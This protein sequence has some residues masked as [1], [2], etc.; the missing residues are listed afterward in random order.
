MSLCLVSLCEVSNA[1]CHNAEVSLCRMPLIWVSRILSVIMLCSYRWISLCC[2]LRAKCL[3]PECHNGECHG[4]KTR[5]AGHFRFPPISISIGE[6]FR[7]KK[8]ILGERRIHN[9]SRGLSSIT[10][11][12]SPWRSY[13]V[14]WSLSVTS[15]GATFSITAYSITT[16]SITA[17]CLTSPSITTHSITTLSIITLCL[18]SLS[19]ATS[20]MQH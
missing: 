6:K 8:Y 19:I 18:T 4:V 7:N 9:S 2:A 12:R 3:F 14:G 20:K 16:Y 15:S 1:W 11:Y 17:L 5:A 13:L 10:F